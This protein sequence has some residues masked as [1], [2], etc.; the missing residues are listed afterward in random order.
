MKEERIRRKNEFEV[1]QQEQANEYR[2]IV[3]EFLKDGQEM[4]VTDM[5]C[6]CENLKNARIQPLSRCL[7]DLCEQG[8]VKEEISK[9]KKYYSIII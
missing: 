5:I 6:K 4:T 9:K 7:E 8:L 2:N 1:K 3:L